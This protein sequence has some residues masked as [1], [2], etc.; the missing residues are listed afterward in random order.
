MVKQ[1]ENGSAIRI[2]IN[3]LRKWRIH[4][5]MNEQRGIKTSTFRHKFWLYT[6]QMILCIVFSGGRETRRGSIKVSH[7][8]RGCRKSH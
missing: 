7:A 8:E 3:E 2:N 1:L 4:L 5:T 6:L